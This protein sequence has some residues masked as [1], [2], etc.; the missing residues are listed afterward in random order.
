MQMELFSHF[1]P[2]VD[3]VRASEGAWRQPC[4]T[5]LVWMCGRVF[6]ARFVAG[7]LVVRLVRD[8]P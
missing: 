6:A 8:R 4:V 3:D 1:H 7:G 5:T 2:P